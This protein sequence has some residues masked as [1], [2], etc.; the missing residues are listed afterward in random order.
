[1]EAKSG[2]WGMRDPFADHSGAELR[3]NQRL[4]GQCGAKRLETTVVQAGEE[5]LVVLVK[6]VVLG[7]PGELQGE[8][9]SW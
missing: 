8:E 9:D 7:E 5:T 4:K 6:L 2:E 3:W 1:M